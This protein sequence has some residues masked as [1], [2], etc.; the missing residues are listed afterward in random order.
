MYYI[1]VMPSEADN[2]Y[3]NIIIGECETFTH[4]F[5]YGFILIFSDAEFIKIIIHFM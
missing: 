3:F 2:T 5:I 1:E 4:E